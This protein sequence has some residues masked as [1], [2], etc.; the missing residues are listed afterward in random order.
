MK[1]LLRDFLDFYRNQLLIGF[2]RKRGK[3]LVIPHVIFCIERLL[4]EYPEKEEIRVLDLGTGE[5]HLLR[6]IEQVGKISGFAKKLK[7]YGF[8][9]DEEML[10]SAR[11]QNNV[12]A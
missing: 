1:E 2:F 3:S 6:V 9:Y 7:L 11:R 5:G 10:E 12:K 4:D 8:D